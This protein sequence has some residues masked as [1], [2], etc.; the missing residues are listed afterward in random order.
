MTHRPP[1]STRTDTL[2]PYTTL[3][4]SQRG[5]GISEAA[6]PFLDRRV[7]LLRKFTADPDTR[8]IEE[9]MTIDRADID[10]SAVTLDNDVGR[11]CEVERDGKGARQVIRGSGGNDSQ[12]QAALDH[13]RRSG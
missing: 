10:P 9:G 2:F 3:C 6:E 1:R 12:R 11:R 8:D 4:R 13:S 5:D 7:E